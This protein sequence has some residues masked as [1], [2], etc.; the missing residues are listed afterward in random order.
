MT[1]ARSDRPDFTRAGAGALPQLELTDAGEV[2]HVG[3]AP[4][5]WAWVPWEYA[6][7]SGLFDGRWDDQLGQFRTLYT[8]DSLLGC[9]LELLSRFRVSPSVQTALAEIMDDDGSVGRY[10]DAPP[11]SLG[12]RW[13]ET[14][15]YGRAQQVGRYCAITHSRSIAALI[16]HYPLG[17]HGL[18]P[19]DV[20][21]ALLK[22][23]R[24]RDF[25]RSIARWLYDLHDRGEPLIDG[26]QFASRHGDELRMWAVFERADSPHRS[27]QIVPVSEPVSVSPD[28]PELLEAF[29][30]FGLRWYEP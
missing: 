3:F 18:S 14:R 1:D 28:T 26:V 19:R 10:P 12:R 25:T 21:A 15:M 2:W 6:N 29:E 9:F 8:A 16:R 23:A 7:D 27:S 13:L 11:G 4:D 17:R 5:P 30:R 22:D 24:D 20:D